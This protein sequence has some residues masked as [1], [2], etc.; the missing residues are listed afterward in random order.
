MSTKISPETINLAVSQILKNSFLNKKNFVETI[1]LQIG[2]KNYD[3]KKDKRFSGTITLPNIPKPNKKIAILGDA[4]HLTEAT[5][6][7]IDAYG[8]ED[9]K[10]FNKQKKPIKKFSKKYDFF[11]ASDSIIRS[12]PRI[13]GPGLNKVGKFP[14]LLSHSEDLI[15]KIKII[16]S[17]IKLELKKV[18]CLGVS[19]GNVKMDN[20][21]IVQNI[22]LAINFLLSLLKKNWQNIKSLHLKSTMGKPFRI[23]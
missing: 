15:E 20:E 17:N 9:L 6:L 3:P 18:L 11:L 19:I 23:Y 22:S 8:I 4:V 21:K 13:L 14:V 12:I 5:R 7:Q 16:K 10:K 2:L 1:E